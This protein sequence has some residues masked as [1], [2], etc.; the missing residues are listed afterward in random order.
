MA[1]LEKLKSILGLDIFIQNVFVI[2]AK[3][4][5]AFEAVCANMKNIVLLPTFYDFLLRKYVLNIKRMAL[6][7]MLL[8]FAIFKFINYKPIIALL[9]THLKTWWI[10]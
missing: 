7:S 2:D 1:V 4:Q 3:D 6:I 9:C 10:F 5:N 8:S